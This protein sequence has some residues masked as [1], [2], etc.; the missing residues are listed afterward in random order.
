MCFPYDGRFIFLNEARV[1]ELG[2]D[3]SVLEKVD[4]TSIE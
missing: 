4:A 3:V 2:K 1:T